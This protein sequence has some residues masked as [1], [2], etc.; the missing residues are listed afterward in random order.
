ML[1]ASLYLTATPRFQYVGFVP[2][3]CSLMTEETVA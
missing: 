2:A 1:P 3:A